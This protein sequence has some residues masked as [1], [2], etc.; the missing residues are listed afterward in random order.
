MNQNANICYHLIDNKANNNAFVQGISGFFGLPATLM[1]DTGS[2]PL[3]Y[4]TLWN[5]IRA[6]YG[7]EPI[8]KEDA[9]KV[10][11]NIMPEV[12]SDVAFDKIMGN[13]PVVGVYFNAICAKQMTWRLGILFSM[14]SSRGSSVD[15]A[16]CKEAMVLIRKLFPQND[17]F[18]FTTPSHEKFMQLI[19]GVENCHV[20]NFNEKIDKALAIF[21]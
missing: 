6:V 13:V 14:L 9:V 11:V 21:G 15:H 4:A 17:M 1:V 7:Y 5:E 19:G 20:N 8:Q 10:I 2:I 18:K 12:L 3:V 16:N